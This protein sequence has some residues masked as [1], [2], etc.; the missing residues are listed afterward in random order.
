MPLINM[1][2][3]LNGSFSNASTRYEHISQWYC[4]IVNTYLIKVAFTSG[5]KCL[6]FL[7]NF[8]YINF[9]CIL[10]KP[11]INLFQK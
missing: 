6:Y 4:R 2:A 10:M 9:E 1:A 8:F 11:Q 5:R 3:L 7:V